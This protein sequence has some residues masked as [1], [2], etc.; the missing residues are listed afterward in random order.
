MIADKSKAVETHIQ[1]L[2]QLSFEQFTRAVLLA[3]SEVTAF[4]KAR[5]NERGEL[6]EYLTNSSI[7]GKIGQLAYEKTKS[8]ATQRKELENVLGHIE[9]RS[10]EEITALCNQYET[11]QQHYQRLEEEKSQYLQ[12][13]QWFAQRYKLE[14]DI[15]LKQQQ[16][17]IQQQAHAN[18]AQNRQQLNQLETFSAIRPIVFQ[19]QQILNTLQQLEPQIQQQQHHFISLSRQFE[20]EQNRFQHAETTLQDRK[21]V[22]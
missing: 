4:L 15:I 16:Y 11:T 10:E 9:I 19:Q 2:T 17:E 5:D 18:L 21:S 7:F 6:L 3:Q 8:I 22:V 20:Q 13:Q 1:Q 14:Q 12:Q